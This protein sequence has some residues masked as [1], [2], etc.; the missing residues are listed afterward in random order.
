M[1]AKSNARQVESVIKLQIHTWFFKLFGL[2]GFACHGVLDGPPKGDLNWGPFP[3]LFYFFS[4]R[5][6]CLAWLVLLVVFQFVLD[7][8][9]AQ[10]R[11]AN[12]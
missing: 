5:D 4:V 3:R 2:L 8:K 11:S 6:V 10:A 12:P 7:L 1:S 9:E